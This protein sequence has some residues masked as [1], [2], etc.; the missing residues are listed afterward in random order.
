MDELNREFLIAKNKM[1]KLPT[2]EAET[3]VSLN[4]QLVVPEYIVEEV[5]SMCDI[6]HRSFD[7]VLL[8]YLTEEDSIDIDLMDNEEGFDATY[9]VKD[10]IVEE[11]DDHEYI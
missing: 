11:D 3:C 2:P 9:Y 1:F 5:K 7:E 10:L 8:S 6:Q 4:V